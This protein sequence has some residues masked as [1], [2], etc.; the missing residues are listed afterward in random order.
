MMKRPE[1]HDIQII[2]VVAGDH[3]L[4]TPGDDNNRSAYVADLAE[5]DQ[6]TGEASDLPGDPNADYDLIAK[7]GDE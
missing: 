2:C 6:H 7:G 3:M 4:I 5:P 1:S